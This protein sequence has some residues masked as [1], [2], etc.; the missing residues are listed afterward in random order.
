MLYT[1]IT[2]H[3][4]LFKLIYT[5]IKVFAPY[6]NCILFST[7]ALKEDESDDTK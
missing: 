4:L 6:T 5:A 3:H 1:I 2:Q 7:I